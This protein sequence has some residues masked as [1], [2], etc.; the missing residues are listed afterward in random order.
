MAAAGDYTYALE[1]NADNS[2]AG[3]VGARSA[4]TQV[5]NSESLGTY[6]RPLHVFKYMHIHEFMKG[7]SQSGNPAGTLGAGAQVRDG[8][9]ALH[10]SS[11]QEEEDAED[12]DGKNKDK[13]HEGEQGRRSRG[14][15]SKQAQQE[16]AAAAAAAAAAGDAGIL[17]DQDFLNKGYYVWEAVRSGDGGGGGVARARVAAN[18]REPLDTDDMENQLEDSDIEVFSQPIPLTELVEVL[19]ELWQGE[20]TL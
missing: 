17:L 15:R 1:I 10:L 7:R 19:D 6:Q 2:W 9:R 12:Q 20:R 11:K 18:R 13:R 5:M 8:K 3:E 16:E 14:G 4:R